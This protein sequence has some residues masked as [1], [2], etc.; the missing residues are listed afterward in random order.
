MY[1]RGRE[2]NL[3]G[4]LSW[5]V[6]LTAEIVVEVHFVSGLALLDDGAHHGS[7]V[8]GGHGLYNGVRKEN[9]HS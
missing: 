9:L 6:L 7:C 8:L 5:K 3:I 4:S 2:N 1:K